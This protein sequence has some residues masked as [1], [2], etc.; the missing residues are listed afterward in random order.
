MKLLFFDLETTGTN[1]ARHGIHQISGM[2][3]IDGVERERFDFKVRPNP[4]AE[5]LDEALAVGGVTREQI[6]SYPPMEDVYRDFVGMLS[7]YVNKFNK[8]DKFFLV[9]YNNAAFDNQFLRG[10]FLQNG[11]NYFGSWFWSNSVDVMVLASQYLPAERPLMPNFKLS[12]VASQL[13]VSVSEDKLHDALYDIYLTRE[14]YHLMID[15]ARDDE[16]R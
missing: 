14:A 7:R 10:F 13:G 15:E 6:E 1:P 3:E 16:N 2:I 9:G 8:A 12:T 5:V 4:K 11:D